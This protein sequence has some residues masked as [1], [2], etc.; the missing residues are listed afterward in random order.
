MIVKELFLS[1]GFENIISA[2]RN[3]HRN[4]R[5][6]ENVAAY[7]EAFDIICLTEFVG[8]LMTYRAKL[9]YALSVYQT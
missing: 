2:L 5:S 3:T 1:V 7:K 6:I 9:L 8:T 4:D